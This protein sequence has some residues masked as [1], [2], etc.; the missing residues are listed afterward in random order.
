MHVCV[1]LAQKHTHTQAHKHTH[2]HTHTHAHDVCVRACTHSQT[3]IH[4]RT[5]ACT[6]ANT[7]T[8]RHRPKH[9]HTKVPTCTSAKECCDTHNTHTYMHTHRQGH[10]CPSSIHTCIQMKLVSLHRTSWCWYFHIYR[11]TCIY[12]SHGMT[13]SR[14]CSTLVWSDQCFQLQDGYHWSL[15]DI[16]QVC[17]CV[18]MCVCEYV[19]DW[20]QS[21]VIF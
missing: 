16:Q 14:Q 11:H 17:V 4:A 15:L 8:H 2:T 20:N 18:C 12:A 1:F 10:A 5:H 9:T 7:H 13:I 3:T 6:H 19:S 21:T